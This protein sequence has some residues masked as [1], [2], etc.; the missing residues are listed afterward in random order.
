MLRQKVLVFLYYSS[1]GK[2]E[3]G[4]KFSREKLAKTPSHVDTLGRDIYLK[5]TDWPELYQTKPIKR[6]QSKLIK[7]PL[8]LKKTLEKELA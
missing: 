3:V 7:L 1:E 6:L 8:I 5:Q 2:V 4:L